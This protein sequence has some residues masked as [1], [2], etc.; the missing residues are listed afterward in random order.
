MEV[1]GICEGAG[2]SKDT[3][4][5]FSIGLKIWEEPGNF[6]SLT[7]YFRDKAKPRGV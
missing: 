1:R 4:G 7:T 5:D 6:G 2:L 3:F